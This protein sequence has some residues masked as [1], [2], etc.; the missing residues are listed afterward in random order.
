MELMNYYYSNKNNEETKE[1]EYF[2]K[3][4]DLFSSDSI[5]KTNLMIF[6]S[7]LIRKEEKYE[8][9][10][11]KQ[12]KEI[13]FLEE[14]YKILKEINEEIEQMNESEKI[15]FEKKLNYTDE[16]VNYQEN[17]IKLKIKK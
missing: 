3:I 7:K 16:M 12:K 13:K 1:L 15:N 9:L 5:S 14:N 17:V 2:F 10:T 4:F 8:L 6:L 11:L